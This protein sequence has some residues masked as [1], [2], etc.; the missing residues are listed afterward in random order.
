[1]AV[2]SRSFLDTAVFPIRYL[3]AEPIGVAQL[4]GLAAEIYGEAVPDDVLSATHTVRLSKED[5]KLTLR[6]SLPN[7][8]RS[9]LDIQRKGRELLIAAGG[10]WRVFA[11]PDTLAECEVEGATYTDGHLVVSFAEDAQAPPGAT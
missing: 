5:G 8:D 10:H 6:F 1:M 7:L 2:I 3:A 4:D 11:L 9:S